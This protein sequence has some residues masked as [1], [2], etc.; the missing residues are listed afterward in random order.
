MR[1]PRFRRLLTSLRVKTQ[2]QSSGMMGRRKAAGLLIGSERIFVTTELMLSSNARLPVVALLASVLTQKAV[3]ILNRSPKR[4]NGPGER[5]RTDANCL[6]CL[7][8]A[9]KPA[10]NAKVTVS[11]TFRSQTIYH[12][13]SLRPC[14]CN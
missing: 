8:I 4:A 1:G 5:N 12:Y 11:G 3:L 14:H 9:H 7:V 6:L 13:L 10:I 2:M